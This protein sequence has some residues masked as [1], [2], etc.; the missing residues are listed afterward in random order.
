M[1]DQRKEAMAAEGRKASAGD[2]ANK[3]KTS[4]SQDAQPSPLALLAATC[5]KIGGAAGDGQAGG[6]QPPPA[7]QIIIDPNQGLVQPQPLELVTAQL[8]GGGWQIVAA[9]PALA[10]EPATPAGAQDNNEG[11][12][13]R[14]VKATGP[15]HVAPAGQQQQQLQVIQLQTIPGTP[16][17]VLTTLPV[18]IGG[19]TLALPVINSVPAGGGPLQ[20]VPPPDGG[21]SN[22]GQLVA[23]SVSTVTEPAANSGCNVVTEAGQLNATP[24]AADSCAERE[25]QETQPP[26]SDAHGP[27]QAQTNGLPPPQEPTSHIQPVQIVGQPVLQHIHIQQPQQQQQQQQQPQL[28][29]GL[30]LQPGHTVQA[31]PLQN[32][33]LQAVQSPAQLF[34][35][36]PTLT[37]SGQISWQAV[38][39]QNAGLPQQLT[40]TPVTA[41]T[42]GGAFAQITPLALGS[43]PITLNTAQ[44]T[45]VPSIQTVNIANL[46]AAGV[47]LQGVPLTITGQQ[48]S[49]D[50]VKVQAAPVTV[51]VG[52]VSAVSP[53]QMAQ[54]QMQ[55]N[56]TPSEQDV[57]PGKRLRRVACSC[58][59][60]RDG[61]GRRPGKKK[62][63]VCHMEGCGKVY[64]KTSHLR[65]HLRWHTGERPFVCNW[66]FCGKRFTRSDELQR[67][68]RTHTGEKRFECPECSKRFMRSDHL[69]K[70]IKTHQNKKGGAALAIV[71]TEDME[72]TV[73]QVLDSPAIVGSVSLSQDSNPATPNAAG[74]MDGF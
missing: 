50:G 23:T 35:R 4:A 55:Q 9:S 70:H 24:S 53:D 29:Q 12:L 19:V 22:G 32:V 69:S 45:S 52:N 28:I 36:A 11:P 17:Q 6:G 18:N 37:P 68:R 8:A 10:K 62:Q 67:H 73:S 64:G 54:V 46:G 51:T 15:S 34:I 40:L 41:G 44:L 14:K 65:A 60:C 13:G 1:S 20:L 21:V 61:D 25:P 48:Q 63:H 31:Q 7:Q 56:Q 43:A 58:P 66:I 26:D 71:T 38:Q 49:Q 57:Q 3:G 59:N 33:Q 39:V 30:Q 5:S 74:T 47:Q 72:E 27:N 2:C 42:S 16:A